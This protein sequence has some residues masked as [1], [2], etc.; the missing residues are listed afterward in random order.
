MGAALASYRDPLPGAQEWRETEVRFSATGTGADA[1][2][3]KLS[4]FLRRRSS[5]DTVAAMCTP[6][7]ESLDF[8]SSSSRILSK[9][10]PRP[11][12]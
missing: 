1:L 5:C 9:L 2:I 10:A 11:A 6:S 3:M 4:K 7:D 12:K 8:S